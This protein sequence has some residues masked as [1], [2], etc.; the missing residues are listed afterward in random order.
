MRILTH[1][2]VSTEHS[3]LLAQVKQV[4]STIEASSYPREEVFRILKNY[5]EFIGNDQKAMAN[6]QRLALP[7]SCCVIAGQQLG[8]MGG[9]AYTILK[10]ISCLLLAKEIEAVPIFWLATEDHDIGEIDHTYGIDSLGNLKKFRLAFPKNG[11]SVED[12][13]I[14]ENH[15]EE[16]RHFWEFMDIPESVPFP[17][18]GE[19]Y[20][21][22]MAR[23][24]VHLFAG[25]GMV[26]LEPK[27]LRPLAIPFFSREIT[28]WQAIQEVLQATTHRL[29]KEGRQPPVHIGDG[30]T[31]F[32]KDSLGKRTK[33]HVEGDSFAAG[34]ECYTL[35]E[36][37][38]KI[39]NEP[40][41]F[42]PNVVARPALQNTLLP[43]VAAI[44]G[45]TEMEY[46]HQLTDYFFYH[47]LVAPQLISRSSVT[48][49]PAEAANVLE[50]CKLNP[51]DSIPQHWP[52]PLSSLGLPNHA[53]HLLNNLIHPHQSP[54]DRVLNWWTFQAKTTENLVHMCLQQLSWTSL[55]PYY[56][57]L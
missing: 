10:G 17:A 35:P 33:I 3:D 23:I 44:V 45:P 27:G 54:Q 26:F 39:R 13:T 1:S 40:E 53:L 42:S 12:L 11:L 36:L 18:V 50:K 8:L 19:L 15:I 24:L 22:A 29:V 34:K 57:Y 4:K 38:L 48:F 5:N 41:R 52:E 49:I 9:P 6:I 20:S 56:C 28:E 46:H 47:K 25:T 31:L 51:W 43:V 55:T 21:T 16:L 7:K 32:M 30:T 14:T 37:L 2:A